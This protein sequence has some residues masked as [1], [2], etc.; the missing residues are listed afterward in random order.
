M[1][2]GGRRIWP[3]G[4]RS[5]RSDVRWFPHVGLE[6]H[7]WRRRAWQ[8]SQ[9]RTGLGEAGRGSS[10]SEQLLQKISPQFL[11]WCWAEIQKESLT[12]KL[13][14][15]CGAFRQQHL[16][17]QRSCWVPASCLIMHEYFLI[18]CTQNAVVVGNE[19]YKWL[20]ALPAEEQRSKQDINT[21]GRAFKWVSNRRGEKVWGSLTSATTYEGSGE[22]FQYNDSLNK[23][24]QTQNAE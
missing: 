16:S 13:T 12:L 9:T 20:S 6:E 21:N 8:V 5:N 4:R 24:F 3:I 15:L 2:E 23:E 22:D 10:L 11:Q 19:N 7:R 17:P 14:L 18:H 1:R